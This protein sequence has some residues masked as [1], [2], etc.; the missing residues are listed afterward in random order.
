ME[1]VRAIVCNKQI[2]SLFPN[3]RNCRCKKKRILMAR[4]YIWPA[5]T[6]VLTTCACIGVDPLFL[7]G[8]AVCVFSSSSSI[9]CINSNVV[10]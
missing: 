4:V 7:T 10:L 6:R 3:L 5:K 8:I 1:V 9:V 2:M